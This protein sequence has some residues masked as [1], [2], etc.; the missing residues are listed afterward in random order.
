MNQYYTFFYIPIV[1]IILHSIDT[2]KHLPFYIF[3]YISVI[4]YTRSYIIHCWNIK[5]WIFIK[6]IT[7]CSSYLDISIVSH[8][9]LSFNSWITW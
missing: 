2:Q 8:W 4:F 3:N 1:S 5:Q 7:Q 9:L 6:N